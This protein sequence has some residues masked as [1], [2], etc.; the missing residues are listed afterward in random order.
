MDIF[1]TTLIL[2]KKTVE[3]AEIKVQS[4]FFSLRTYSYNFFS[5]A[6]APEK[7][8]IDARGAG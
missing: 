3:N 5:G 1:L 7:K 4:E 2:K 8:N 6:P